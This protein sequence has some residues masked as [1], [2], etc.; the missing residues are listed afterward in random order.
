MCLSIL[1]L[2][3]RFTL[4]SFTLERK[5]WMWNV[6]CC[7]LS[8]RSCQT[9]CR[10]DSTIRQISN[11]RFLSYSKKKC[12]VTDKIVMETTTHRTV[13]QTTCT[14]IRMVANTPAVGTTNT[15][16]LL[17]VIAV[18]FYTFDSISFISYNRLAL[19]FQHKHL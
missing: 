5:L 7:L 15:I 2:I 11:F 18:S 1:I 8:S 16:H 14:T 6:D 13:V 17:L 19:Q 9:K 4:L 10:V 12:H 3:S